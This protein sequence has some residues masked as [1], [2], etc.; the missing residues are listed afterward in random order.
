MKQYAI[1]IDLDRCIGCRGGC[2]VACKTEHDIELGPSRSTLYTMGPFGV[3]PDLEMYFL[4]V[5][6]QQCKAPACVKACPTGACY[7]DVTDGVVRID[8]KS[9]VGCRKCQRAC[10]YDAVF[11]RPKLKVA[12]KCDLCSK[13]RAEGLEPVCVTNCAGGAIMFGDVDDENSAV[14]LALK[15]AG[16]HV[17]ALNDPGVHPSG[18]F[19]LR[20]ARWHEPELKHK[21]AVNEQSVNEQ[22]D[23]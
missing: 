6:C 19:I 5:M 12:D 16:H 23:V 18:R 20:G 9:C 7:K 8:R 14:S 11:Y 2:Q 4:P 21:G 22:E 17:Y 3:F 15:S 13:R 1:V 10:P